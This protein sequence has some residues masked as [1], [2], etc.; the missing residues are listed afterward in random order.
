MN[1]VYL[2]FVMNFMTKLNEIISIPSLSREE[3]KLI[4]LS[5]L[6]SFILLSV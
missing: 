3:R 5:Y 2:K 1:Y 4:S 6:H